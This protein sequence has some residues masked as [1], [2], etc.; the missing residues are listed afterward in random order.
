ME[1]W[2]D[3][4]NESTEEKQGFEIC[5]DTEA[6]WALR[7]IA[8]DEAERDRLNAVCEN[9]LRHYEAEMERNNQKCEQSTAYLRGQLEA[10]FERVPHRKTKTQEIYALP[11][12]KLALK[13]QGPDYERDDDALI[14]WLEDN[15]Y[16]DLIEYSRR[17]RWG[18]L[19]KRLSASGENAVYAETGEVVQGLK[20]VARA[21]K[22]VIQHKGGDA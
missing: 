3:D 11:S 17:P 15:R 1:N 4:L 8:Q 6:E 10:Y 2:S 19:K 20:A 21:P 9:M 22:F 5:T 16:D 13:I 7:T 12:G 18:E 14:N